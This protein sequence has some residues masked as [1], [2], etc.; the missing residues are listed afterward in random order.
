MKRIVIAFLLPM[1]TLLTQ[2]APMALAHSQVV[3]QNPQPD[4]QISTLPTKVE[5]TFNEELISLGEGNQLQ[6]L[7]PD[8]D[9]VTS[10]ELITSG[11]TLSR[12]LIAS[13]Q[14]GEYYVSYRAVSADGHVVAG[15]YKF[16]L[17]ATPAPLIDDAPQVD[18][19]EAGES[20]RN[21]FISSLSFLPLLIAGLLFWRFR[22]KK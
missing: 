13:T 17:T 5:I 15:E 1:L 21:L 8:G 11:S 10:G 2:S 20:G 6:L 9:E 12:A 16:T 14:L 22:S 7:D 4:A 18:I 3:S 19:P